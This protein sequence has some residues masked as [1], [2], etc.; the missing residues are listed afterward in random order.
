MNIEIN[1][2]G[3]CLDSNWTYIA[4][5][6]QI[7]TTGAILFAGYKLFKKYFWKSKLGKGLA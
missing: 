7:L 2:F 1:S 5:S 6:W 4:L 3:I